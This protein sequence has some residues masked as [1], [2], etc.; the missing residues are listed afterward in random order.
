M[1][2]TLKESFLLLAANPHLTLL[3]VIYLLIYV[4]M[5]PLVVWSYGSHFFILI[6]SLIFL[7][8]AAF[9]SGWF[10]LIKFDIANKAGKTTQEHY[11]KHKEAFFASIPSYMLS[12][13]AFGFLFFIVY[14]ILGYLSIIIFAMSEEDSRQ[15]L[16]ILSNADSIVNLVNTCPE[17]IKTL[18]LRR[19]IFLYGGLS[20][21][22]FLNL[23]SIPA[24]Y[25]SNSKNPL[26]ALKNGLCALFKR[27]FEN[28]ALFFS[29]IA[30]FA[31]VFVFRIYTYNSEIAAFLALV[32]CV[33]FAVYI[34]VLLFSIY[35]AN[36]ADN[37]NNGGNCLG[38][39]DS[40]D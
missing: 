2:F 10:G 40:C 16:A 34:L 25:F 39:N 29:V 21:Y 23:Y 11:S 15:F 38:Q 31:I 9:F 28:L 37:C 12:L 36:F 8:A 27:F 6:V 30:F 14:Y 35:E 5:C 13:I 3:F 20:L 22:L 1:N 26:I 4:S 17:Q 7:F 19:S 18:L 32:L 33:S 24:L